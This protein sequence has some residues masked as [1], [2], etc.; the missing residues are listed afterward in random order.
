VTPQT[1]LRW[2][3]ELVRRKWSRGAGRRPGRPSLA[4][5]TRAVILKLARENPRWGYQ[6]RPVYLVTSHFFEHVLDYVYIFLLVVAVGG[7]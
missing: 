3:P 5:A 2:H 4:E 7:R 1:V 6:R